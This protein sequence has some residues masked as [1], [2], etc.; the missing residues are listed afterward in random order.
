M[1]EEEEGMDSSVK[2]NKKK[3]G[4]KSGGGFFAKRGEIGCC[5]KGRASSFFWHACLWFDD[6]P[7][8]VESRRESSNLSPSLSIRLGKKD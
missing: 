5:W 6:K 1:E 3:E 7:A 8:P 4:G 2:Y